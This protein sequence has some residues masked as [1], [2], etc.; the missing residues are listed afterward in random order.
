ML[1]FTEAAVLMQLRQGPAH[2]TDI[3][4]A[5]FPQV[6]TRYVP[7]G[8]QKQGQLC[9]HRWAMNALRRPRQDGLVVSVGKGRYQLSQKGQVRVADLAQAG[10]VGPRRLKAIRC[11]RMSQEALGQASGLGRPRIAK[12]E[13]G[14]GTP[15]TS[16]E[17]AQLCYALFQQPEVA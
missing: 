10:P 9:R 2:V 16:T 7:Y 1:S 11:G 12:L 6:E 15:M 8:T 3:G 13:Q 17:A 4:D 14:R 5:V